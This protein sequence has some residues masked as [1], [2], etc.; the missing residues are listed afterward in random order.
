MAVV[1]K[2]GANAKNVYLFGEDDSTT[3][4]LPDGSEIFVHSTGAVLRYQNKND[5]IGRQLS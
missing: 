5:S 3:I 2:N 1:D 4:H